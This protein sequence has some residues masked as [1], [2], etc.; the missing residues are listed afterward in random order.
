MYI[1]HW[2]MPPCRATHSGFFIL[3]HAIHELSSLSICLQL[4]TLADGLGQD[5]V[6]Q[7]V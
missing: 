6:L 4:I 3:N 2:S 5:L 7:M 1:G